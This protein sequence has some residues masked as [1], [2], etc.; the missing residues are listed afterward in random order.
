[1]LPLVQT[2]AC[3]VA[4]KQHPRLIELT[5]SGADSTVKLWDVGTR[6]AV[7]STTTTA[8]NWAMAWQPPNLGYGTGKQFAVAGDEKA[9][10]IYRAAGSA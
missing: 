9:V 8:A 10:T 6:T 3:L 5:Y 2:V 7:F 4:R 1:M